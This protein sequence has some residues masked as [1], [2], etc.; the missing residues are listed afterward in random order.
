MA[1]FRYQALDAQGK[2]RR[3]VQQADSARHARQLLRDKGWLALEV[4]AADPAS[5]LWRGGLIAR[6]TS[7]GDLALLTRQLATLVAAGIPLEKALDAVAPQCA[8]AS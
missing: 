6:R 2:T 3:G 7:A 5:R 4:A 8:T 1:L